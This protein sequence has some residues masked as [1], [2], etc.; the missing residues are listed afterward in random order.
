[1]KWIIHTEFQ[2]ADF[3]EKGRKQ[4]KLEPG[5]SSVSTGCSSTCLYE[6]PDSVGFLSCNLCMAQ[7][8]YGISF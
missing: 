8:N 3:S 6:L 5:S 4:D 1:M 2:M 7:L